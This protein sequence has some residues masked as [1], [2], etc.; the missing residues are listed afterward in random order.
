[1][2]HHHAHH[3]DHHHPSHAARTSAADRKRL[4][5]ILGI[6]ATYMVA[7]YVGAIYTSSLALL[8]D[9]THMFSDVAALA[10]SLFALWFA[11]RPASSQRTFGHY[12]T[13][14]LAALANGAALI[15][16]AILIFVEAYQRIHTPHGVRGEA[17]AGIAAGG[18]LV[19]VIAMWI[20][21]GGRQNSLNMRGAWLHVMSDALG[22]VGAIIS[23]LCI[24]A[25]GWVWLDPAVSVVIGL[26]VIYS[27][28]N[29]LKETLAVL[30]EA[31][32][33]HIN[34]DEV[35][36]AMRGVAGV[37]AIHDLHVWTITSGRESLS[38]HVVGDGTVDHA[39]LLTAMRTV[40]HDQ[41]DMT[42]VTLQIEPED[43]VPDP[44]C[45]QC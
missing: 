27:S 23:G 25:F 35:H 20:L 45:L 34:V 36:R 16:I 33:G 44:H 38:A 29:L 11:Q 2:A 28:W 1:M 26:L 18:L 43:Y 42:H 40:L 9:A 8:A 7:E 10:L 15:A 12:R 39:T 6:T 24:W 4:G 32:P 19:N 5:F 37:K 13:E 21:H 31:A 41:F 30:M 14:I 3:R 22:S 17:M